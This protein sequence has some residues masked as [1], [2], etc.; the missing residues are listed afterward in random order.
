MQLTNSTR[1]IEIVLNDKDTIDINLHIK[2]KITKSNLTLPNSAKCEIFN[3][4]EKTLTKLEALPK[5]KIYL[6]GKILFTGKVINCPNEYAGTSW[7]C[8]LY[9]SDIETNPYIQPQYVEILKG[10]SNDQV[11]NQMGKLI[12]NFGIDT[13]AFKEC[14]KAKGSLLK[15]MV[16]EYKKEGDVMKALQNMFKDCNTEVI[17][18]DGVVKL[19]DRTTVPNKTKP[20]VFDK[21]FKSPRLSIKDIVVDIPLNHKIKLGL[22]FEVKA[23]SIVR[24]LASPYT[25]KQKFENR[26][27]RIS[28]FTHEFDNYS[29]AVARTYVKGLNIG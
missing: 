16:V 1:K 8:T 15:G 22:G 11:I 28:E 26:I 14:A 4:S 25:Y 20:L 17:K 18:E 5:V 9:C 13:S 19:Q 3:I 10:T 21:F 7:V 12:S 27:Y 2:C 29:K 6:D 23:K 24:K